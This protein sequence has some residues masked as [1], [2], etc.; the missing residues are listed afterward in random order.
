MQKPGILWTFWTLPCRI[1]E[2]IELQTMGGVFEQTVIGIVQ[3][4]KNKT[5]IRNMLKLYI[6][7]LFNSKTNYSYWCCA[8]KPLICTINSFNI[9]LCFL[10]LFT[11]PWNSSIEFEVLTLT[12]LSEMTWKRVGKLTQLGQNLLGCERVSTNLWNAF[13]K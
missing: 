2:Y 3:Y 8:C 7:I 1:F 6:Y 9:G 12:L 5:E 4:L 10:A 13:H 11:H